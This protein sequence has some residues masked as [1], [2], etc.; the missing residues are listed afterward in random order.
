MG[1]AVGAGR[2]GS[3]M[4]G[5][6]LLTSLLPGCASERAGRQP[7][8]P[9]S[10]A[11]AAPGPKPTP[12]PEP[13]DF[14]TRVRPLLEEKCSP[15]HFPGGRMYDRMPF[16]RE[17]TIRTLGES[18]LSRLR[19]PVDQDLLRTFLAPTWGGKPSGPSGR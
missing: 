12:A 14:A 3:W 13:I 7:A 10:E 18:M 15:C 11:A 9:A 4:T 19:D 2:I 6:L 8:A 5:A 17:E 1:I 16:D